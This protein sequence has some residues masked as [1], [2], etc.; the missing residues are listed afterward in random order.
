MSANTRAATRGVSVGQVAK[1]ALLIALIILNIRATLPTE[2]TLSGFGSFVASGRAA[3][4]GLDP[5]AIY[6]ETAHGMFAGTMYACPN[7]NPPLSVLAFQV[8]AY[9]DPQTALRA[10]YVISAGLYLAALALLVRAYPKQLTLLRAIWALNLAGLWHTLLLGQIYM[11]L[12]LATTGAWLLLQRRQQLA[13]GTLIGLVVALKPNFAIWPLLL[14][15]AGP[16]VVAGASLASAAALSALPLAAYG[17]RI[18]GQWLAAAGA[19][20][21]L[22]ILP[23]N[24]SLAAIATRL[25]LPWLGTLL[26][27]ALVLALAYVLWCRRPNPLAASGVALAASILASPIAWTGYTLLLLPVL[28]S[29]RWGRLLGVGAMLLLFPLALVWPWC[30]ASRIWLIVLG[31][32]Y[33]WALLLIMAGL[34]GEDS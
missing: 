20:G 29:R 23:G 15:A 27:A 9:V 8:L 21:L 31:S 24:G 22:A 26:A 25:G 3:A 4:A 32:A 7:L 30:E 13:A 5:Y 34:L 14:L 18:Y 19:P 6:P 17:L 28:F 2:D 12:V 10:W 11:P 33:G 16:P 1:I